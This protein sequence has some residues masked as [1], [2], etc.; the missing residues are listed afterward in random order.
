LRKD[1]WKRHMTRIHQ[2]KDLPEPIEYEMSTG[3]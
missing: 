1:N 2:V 3:A